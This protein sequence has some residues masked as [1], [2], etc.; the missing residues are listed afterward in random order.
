MFEYWINDQR[1]NLANLLVRV[2]E[3][4]GKSVR[5]AAGE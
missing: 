2:R 4:R 5:D 1:S 3:Q